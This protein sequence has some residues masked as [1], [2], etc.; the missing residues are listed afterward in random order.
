MELKHTLVCTSVLHRI[1][2][3]MTLARQLL[4]LRRSLNSE[5]N[6]CIYTHGTLNACCI[7]TL[8]D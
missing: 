6:I 8:A 3:I 4:I 7:S 2:I 1:N 5:V